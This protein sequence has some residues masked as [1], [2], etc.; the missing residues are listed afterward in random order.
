MTHLTDGQLRAHVD[1]ELGPADARH[2][3]T[4]PECQARLAS[5]AGQQT[6]VAGQLAALAPRQAAPA[7]QSAWL[8]FQSKYQFEIEKEKQLMSKKFWPRL[9][10]VLAGVAA[11][12]A[13]VAAFTFAPV[14]QAFSAF[15]GLFRAQ[16]VTVLPID[17][18]GLSA[19]SGDEALGR[20]I[21]QML[22]GAA[23]VTRE[24][25][26]PQ[27]AKSAEEASQ[28]AGFTVRLPGNRSDLS[29]LVVQSG[30]AFS[31]S[32]D[33]AEAQDVLSAMGR[34]DLQL[35]ASLDG[36]SI[37]VDV[38]SGV[39]AA[40]GTCPAPDAQAGEVII[41]RA[42]DGDPVLKSGA[43]GRRFFNCTI[44]AQLPSPSVT[45]PP[46]LDVN[47]LALIGLQ[48][49]GMTEAQAR[50]YSQTVDWASTLVIPIPRN[51]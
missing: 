13:I 19:L 38:P 32:V 46:D 42:P 7:A 23:T 44:F 24:P 29:S 31:F 48:L 36:A 37:S 47:E 43:P 6:R 5:L 25:G 3:S 35:P 27:T 14:Q 17:P 30:G 45:T 40:Y 16:S 28:L 41:K 22:S 18:T 15:L 10:P 12:V 21:S 8:K 9:R 1:G 2:L 49:S 34:D 20:Q 51:G 11:L 39:S 26:Q 33:R 4:C 50:E